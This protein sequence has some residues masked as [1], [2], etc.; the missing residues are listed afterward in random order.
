MREHPLDTSVERPEA[1]FSLLEVMIA[2]TIL[3]FGLLGVAIMQIQALSQGSAGRHSGDAA[4][5]ARTYLE[6][7]H[8]VPWSV[9]TAVEG[10]GWSAPNWTGANSTE[11]VVVA[12]PGGGTATEQSYTVEWR[13]D[14]VAGNACLRDVQVRVSWNEE[15]M[16]QPKRLVLATRRYDWGGASC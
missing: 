4:A 8:R 9:S 16:S 5:I 11:S 14:D 7:V 1:G 10:L 6:Q 15:D 3:A 12:V 13:V 2:L